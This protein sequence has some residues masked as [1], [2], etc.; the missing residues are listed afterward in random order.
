[1]FTPSS[2][3]TI[4]YIYTQ[5]NVCYSRQTMPKASKPLNFWLKTFSRKN[6]NKLLQLKTFPAPIR[7]QL[8]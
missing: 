8:N 7:H 2:F 3:D 5:M 4:Y 6:N 1:M